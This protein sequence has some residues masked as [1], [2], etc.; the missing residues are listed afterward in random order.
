MGFFTVNRCDKFGV[1]SATVRD[2]TGTQI[3]YLRAKEFFNFVSEGNI[4]GNWLD[5]AKLVYFLSQ[6]GFRDGVV[7]EGLPYYAPE[8]VLLYYL[9]TV[10][11]GGKTLYVYEIQNRT[12]E[13]WLPNGNFALNLPVG[14][15]VATDTDTMGATKTY[16]WLIRY[17][18]LPGGNWSNHFEDGYGNV[19]SYGFVDTGLRTGSAPTTTSIKTRL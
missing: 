2:C 14:S 11:L 3:G 13:V 9:S 1:S 8:T 16:A 5:P 15:Q 6:S 18:R 7:S 12:E 10:S 19:A 4:C 17:Y